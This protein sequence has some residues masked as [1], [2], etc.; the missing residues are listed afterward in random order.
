MVGEKPSTALNKVISYDNAEIAICSAD[1][2]LEILTFLH[3]Y[4]DMCQWLKIQP[5]NIS[6]HWT[7]MG[8]SFANV[9]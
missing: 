7:C 1:C 4:G 3:H 9:R 8:L 2:K 6:F 5:T